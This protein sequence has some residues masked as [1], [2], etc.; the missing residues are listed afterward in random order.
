MLKEVNLE[1]VRRDAEEAYLQGGLYDAE[2]VVYSIRSNI[3][4]AMPEAVVTAA[5]GFSNGVGESKCMVGAV[6]GGVIALGYFFGRDFPTTPTDPKS[7]KSLKL[8]SELHDAFK[9]NHKVLCSIA[10]E[11]D[12]ETGSLEHKKQCASFSGEVAVKTAE[13]IA[14]EHKLIML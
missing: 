6:A 1:K 13:I 4:P 2:A 11:K 7:Q 3:E 10:L 12:L 14:R 9:K 5:L 8:A